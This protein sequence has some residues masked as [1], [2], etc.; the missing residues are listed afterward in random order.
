MRSRIHW[1]GLSAPGRLAIMARPRAGDW[2][3]D[4]VAAWRDEGIDIVVSLLEPE[5]V[6][7]LGLLSEADLCRGRGMDFV[8]FPISDR[9]GAGLRT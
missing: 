9:G 4:E 1:I 6:A 3:D 2:L 8:A 5:E 7:E